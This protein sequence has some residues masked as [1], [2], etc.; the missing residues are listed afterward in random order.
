MLPVP[1]GPGARTILRDS[2]LAA[3]E[4]PRHNGLVLASTDL[5]FVRDLTDVDPQAQAQ[6]QDLVDVPFV[7]WPARLAGHALGLEPLGGLRAGARL[8]EQLGNPPGPRRLG[9]VQHQLGV[10][11]VVAERHLAAPPHA[12]TLAALWPAQFGIWA[13]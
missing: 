4:I 5:P 6:A 3:P 2:L 8:R 12:V 13:A 10:S 11:R 1:R 7:A 9:L